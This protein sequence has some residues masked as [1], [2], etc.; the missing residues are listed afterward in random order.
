MWP[1]VSGHLA[2]WD[3][4]IRWACFGFS[5]TKEVFNLL[6]FTNF[7]PLSLR[8]MWFG[9]LLDHCHLGG[10]AMPLVAHCQGP[11]RLETRWLLGSVSEICS[12]A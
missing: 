12:T 1:G 3:H 9:F 7:R 6:G 10:D 2:W 11:L 5:F 4:C 8:W